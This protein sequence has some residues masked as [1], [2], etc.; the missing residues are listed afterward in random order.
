M[1]PATELSRCSEVVQEVMV[2]WCPGVI[3]QE[4]LVPWYLGMVVQEYSVFLQRRA[5]STD[6]QKEV[7]KCDLKKKKKIGVEGCSYLLDR[8]LLHF[9]EKNKKFFLRNGSWPS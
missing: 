6:A 7:R 9:E 3:V 5:R 1:M 2:P 8:F 4:G